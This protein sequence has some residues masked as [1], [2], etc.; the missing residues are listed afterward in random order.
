MRNCGI[1]LAG[2]EEDRATGELVVTPEILNP[3]GFVHGGAYYTMGD[4]LCGLLARSDGRQYMT[5]DGN[6]NYI[7]N[8]KEGK[9]TAVSTV[10]H[11]GRSTCLMEVVMISE[12]GAL[13]ATGRFT[14]FCTAQSIEG[15]S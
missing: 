12:T 15:I 9:V 5:L 2:L 11:R 14:F 13:L 1:R 6:M 7:R 10:L 4:C 3:L 8:I